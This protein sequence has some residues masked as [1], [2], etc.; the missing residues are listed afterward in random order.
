MASKLAQYSFS[1]VSAIAAMHFLPLRLNFAR[2][3]NHMTANKLSR[4]E[5]LVGL[6]A[7][8]CIFVMDEKK[9]PH[10]L[11]T[12]KR[13]YHHHK[14]LVGSTRFCDSSVYWVPRTCVPIKLRRAIDSAPLSACLRGR[15]QNSHRCLCTPY[16]KGQSLPGIDP[17][18]PAAWGCKHSPN[19]PQRIARSLGHKSQRR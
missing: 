19:S 17:L 16:L 11:G 9:C 15:S 6:S 10:K 1:S 4:K 2:L 14:L 3:Q 5:P 12:Q 7:E 18:A 8:T 13:H